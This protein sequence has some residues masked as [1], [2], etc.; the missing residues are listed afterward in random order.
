[1]ALLLALLSM[2][3]SA[4]AQ[5][6]LD[7]LRESLRKTELAF[8]ASVAQKD[9]AAFRSFIAD[10]A[11]F[12]GQSPLRGREAIEKDWESFFAPDAPL[13]EWQP[14]DA[15]VLPTGDLGMTRGPYTLTTKDSHG[16]TRRSHGTFMSIWRRQKDGEW[17]IEPIDDTLALA[18]VDHQICL[19]QH[20]QMAR[21]RRLREVE[22]LDDF[23]H[24]PPLPF[25]QLEDLLTR[26]VGKRF[27]HLRHLPLV[28]AALPANACLSS[29]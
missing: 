12:L 3:S 16:E 1:M 25:Q 20:R 13:L 7:A 29:H 19:F 24:A 27:E 28:R 5:Q 6:S 26:L 15:E 18:L 4:P 17:K 11:I 21:D 22:V 8:A 14:V 23:S 9:R 2:T 10:D